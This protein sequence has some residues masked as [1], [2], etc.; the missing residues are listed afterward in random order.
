M[1]ERWVWRGGLVLVAVLGVV[2]AVLA[3]LLLM[4]GRGGAP[5]QQATASLFPVVAAPPASAA[6]QGSASNNGGGSNNGAGGPNGTFT[7]GAA[8]VTGL[9][10]GSHKDLQLVVA[11]P[12]NFDI[13]ITALAAT[14]VA[15]STATCSVSP[16]NLAV[17]AYA[18][19]PALPLVVPG[20]RSIPAGAIPLTMPNTVANGCQNATFTLQ[21]S[22]TA[23]K[24]NQ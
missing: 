8:T 2:A 14:L 15:T 17:S 16:A 23:A 19:P 20:N 18:G 21:L 7:I 24:A 12:Y 5:R 22:G 10:P 4:P 11:N 6:S 9:Y 3:T 13:K 1:S